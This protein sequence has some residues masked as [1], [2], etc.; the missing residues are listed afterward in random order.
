MNAAGRCY[1]LH[2][3]KLPPQSG[4]PDALCSELERAV[5]AVAPNVAYQAEI[6]VVSPSRLVAVL[7]VN[8]RALPEQKF[9]IMDRQLN[10]SA[11]ERFV[12]SLAAEIA[13]TAKP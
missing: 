12:Q 4:G 11:I 1:V 9:A 5:S 6:R 10:R 8:G 3:E 13:K 7:V 2:G